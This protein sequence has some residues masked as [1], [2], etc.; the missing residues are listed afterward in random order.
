MSSN[1]FGGR[2]VREGVDV[3]ALPAGTGRSEFA[4]SKLAE[5]RKLPSRIVRDGEIDHWRI[6]GV[7]KQDRQLYLHGPFLEGIF[8]EEAIGKTFSAALPYLSRLVRAVLAL[9]RRGE[10]LEFIQTDSV[11]FLEDGGVLFLPPALM[12]EL[13]TMHPEPYRLRVF[14]AINH[15]DYEDG[16]KALSFSLA[17]LLYRIILGRYPFEAQSEEEVHNLIRQARLL[18]MSLTEPGF[19]EDL[20]RQILAGLGRGEASAPT[21]EQWQ[22]I[23]ADCK[24]EGLYRDISEQEREQVRRKAELEQQKISKFYRRKVFWQKHWKTVG[25]VAIAVIVV[26]ALAGSMLKNILAPRTTRGFAPSL[27]VETYYR[28]M[29]GLDH[30]VMEDCVVDGAGKQ[31]IREITN[32]YVLSRVSMGYEGRSHIIPADKWDAEGRPELVPPETVYGVTDLEISQQSA[33]PEPVFLASYTKWFPNPP[34]NPEEDMS[35]AQGPGY[36]SMEISERVYLR[37]ERKDWVIYRFEPL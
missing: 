35:E 11:Y 25:I 8:L 24:A 19:R 32:I 3:L 15:P 17:S 21:L 7:I 28:S 6:D 20:S 14:E 23:L 16:E 34:E 29:N 37:L 4:L 13:R 26:G 27:V 10:E 1:E 22:Q 9:R 2:L 31:T 5:L 12:K 18:P 36:V 30:T 33:E